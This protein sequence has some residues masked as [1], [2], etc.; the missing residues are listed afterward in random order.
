M[1]FNIG[2][3]EIVILAVVAF[4]LFGPKAF[5]RNIRRLG[6]HWGRLQSILSNLTDNF[7]LPRPSGTP[8]PDEGED[9][10]KDG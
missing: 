10:R 7:P 1:P 3:G 4:V 6:V 5:L 8:S 9:L 2:L